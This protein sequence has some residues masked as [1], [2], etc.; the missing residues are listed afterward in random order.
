MLE[1]SNV[2][3]NGNGGTHLKSEDH[4]V[5]GDVLLVDDRLVEVGDGDAGPVA[6]TPLPVVPV[7]VVPNVQA[8][9]RQNTLHGGRTWG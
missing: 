5:G 3:N 7:N 6:A 4:L 9:R 8:F 2:Y 1:L